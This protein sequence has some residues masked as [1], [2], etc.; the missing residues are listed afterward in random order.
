MRSN[1]EVKT[2]IG[3][4]K[5][6]FNRKRKLLCSKIDKGLRKRLGK[7][8]DWNVY[9]ED[10][11]WTLRREDKTRLEVFEMWRRIS[12]MEMVTNEVLEK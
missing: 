9:T 11:Y 3:I 2:H 8:F 12:W 5:E 4:A 1:Q 6:A 10:G 7:C